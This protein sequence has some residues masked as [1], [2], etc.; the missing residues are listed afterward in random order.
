VH[1]RITEAFNS[2]NLGDVIAIMQEYFGTEKFTVWHL[3]RDEKRKILKEITEYSLKSAEG[4]FREIYNDNY[5][6]MTGMLQ[7]DIPIPE[8]YKDAVE[9]VI[10]RDLHA[11]FEQD[12][13]KIKRLQRLAKELSKWGT[14]ISD[15]QS[16][17]LAASERIFYEVKKM[18]YSTV[19]LE[20]LQLVNN[21]LETIQDM[22]VDLDVWKTQNTYF[23]MMKG[24]KNG[25]WVFTS[26]EW[27]SAFDRLGELLKVRSL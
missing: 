3:F 7:S 13:L 21:I 15:E 11:F 12:Q 24:F 5:Q 8:A 26:E 14:P 2:T 25:E 23:S 18:A 19:S 4:V 22:G 6:L 17:K 27:K 1:S 20:H 10:N 9:H 16:F